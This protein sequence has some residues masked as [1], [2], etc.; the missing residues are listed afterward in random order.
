MTAS[1]KTQTCPV[2]SGGIQQTIDGTPTFF[3]DT[4]HKKCQMCNHVKS[5]TEFYA[6]NKTYCKE[7]LN[8]IITPQYLDDRERAMYEQDE[9]LLCA[10]RLH[11]SMKISAGKINSVTK[12]PKGRDK[13]ITH[14]VIY[15]LLQNIT[16]CQ[17]C[18]IEF[19]YPFVRERH[20]RS[21]SLDR[22][23]SKRGYELDNL[24]VICWNCNRRKDNSDLE[25]VERLLPYMKNPPNYDFVKI[26]PPLTP[27]S[28]SLSKTLEAYDIDADRQMAEFIKLYGEVSK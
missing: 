8:E 13:N 15:I 12:K 25:F 9:K 14:T 16:Q 5:I 20:P 4:E 24:G 1:E 3:T 6:K 21:P 23:D 18:K 26:A 10:Y 7:C 28:A 11:G 22:I 17:I 27:S 2:P 19:V